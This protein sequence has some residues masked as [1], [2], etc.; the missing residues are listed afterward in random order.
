MKENTSQ[1]RVPH[2]NPRKNLCNHAL[3]NLLHGFLYSF[4]FYRDKN[5]TLGVASN[6]ELTG[7]RLLSCFLYGA[8]DRLI[9]NGLCII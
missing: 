7:N 9:K 4:I 6:T 2:V 8:S 3:R 1:S 5:I